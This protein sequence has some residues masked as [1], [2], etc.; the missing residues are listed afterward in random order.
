MLTC[1]VG[2][3]KYTSI[4]KTEKEFRSLS[5]K[6]ELKCPI[7]D[8][9][10]IYKKGKIKI[11]HFAYKEKPEGDLGFWENETKEHSMGKYYL[12]KWLK[13]FKYVKI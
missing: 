5:K 13:R 4:D 1:K 3:K 10:I 7:T 8:L 11:P 12:Y 9:K 6:G 2:D